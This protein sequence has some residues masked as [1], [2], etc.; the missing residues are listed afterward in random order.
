MRVEILDEAEQDLVD[1][2]RFYE[3][4]DSG[5]FWT[6]F[7]PTLT[8]SNS[9]RGST[10]YSLAIIGFYPNASRTPSTTESKAA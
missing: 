10:P 9:T 1:G 7:F 2:A 3:A 8:R 4:Q 6:P 5:L